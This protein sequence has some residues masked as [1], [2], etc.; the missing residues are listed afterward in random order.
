MFLIS[1]FS[2]FK[3]KPCILYSQICPIKEYKLFS[4]GY[5]SKFKN[6]L[7]V[8]K[9]QNCRNKEYFMFSYGRISKIKNTCCSY[10]LKTAKKRTP[11]LSSRLKRGCRTKKCGGPLLF[12]PRMQL[13]CIPARPQQG[14]LPLRGSPGHLALG[15][16][17]VRGRAYSQ[18]GLSRFW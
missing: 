15:G 17:L 10:I 4:Y 12:I 16:F 3:N 11:H 8:L 7:A 18:P 9:Y 5:L 14:D 1:L 2:F 13:R 6:N